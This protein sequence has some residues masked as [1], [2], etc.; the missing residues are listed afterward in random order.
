MALIAGQVDIPE[1]AISE[2]EAQAVSS[3][4]EVLAAEYDFSVSSRVSAWMGLTSVLVPIVGG[5]F[6]AYKM[7]VAATAPLSVDKDGFLGRKPSASEIQAHAM[8]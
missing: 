8:A 5:H 7:R 6:L 1:V 3:A 2:D 4:L